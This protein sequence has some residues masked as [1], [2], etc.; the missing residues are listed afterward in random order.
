MTPTVHAGQ[1]A[2]NGDQADQQ[3]NSLLMLRARRESNPLTF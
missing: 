1:S 2:G 3:A